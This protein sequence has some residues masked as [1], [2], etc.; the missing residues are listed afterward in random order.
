VSGAQPGVEK[1]VE[2]DGRPIAVH[3]LAVILVEV[4]VISALAWM[5]AS[6]R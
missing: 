2:S 4:A 1:P 5:A 3:Y 6:F